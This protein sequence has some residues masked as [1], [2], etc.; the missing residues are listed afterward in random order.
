MRVFTKQFWLD[1]A[2]RAIKT[3]GQF[4]IVFLG[5]GLVGDATDT[6]EIV[7]VFTIDFLNLGGVFLGGGLVSVLTSLA[8]LAVKGDANIAAPKSGTLAE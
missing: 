1:T 2:E 7:N 6:T 3:G 8:S 5:I 4:A